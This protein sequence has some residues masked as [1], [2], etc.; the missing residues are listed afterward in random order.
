MNNGTS[1]PSYHQ[2]E[3]GQGNLE[4]EGWETDIYV[5]E[6]ACNITADKINKIITEDPMTTNR[7]LKKN[8]TP[9][10]RRS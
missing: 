7:N 10:Q 1:L 3:G 5:F 4:T 9:S 6:N 2:L 8:N